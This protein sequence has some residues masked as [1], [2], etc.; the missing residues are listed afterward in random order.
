MESGRLADRDCGS[1]TLP[2]ACDDLDLEIVEVPAPPLR[3]VCLHE[4]EKI[5]GPLAGKFGSE[6][7]ASCGCRGQARPAVSCTCQPGIRVP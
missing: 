4:C 3:Q 5:S 1:D 6:T 7:G 2:E